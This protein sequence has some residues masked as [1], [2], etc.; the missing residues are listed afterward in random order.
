MKYYFL[1]SYLPE[2][3]REDKKIKIRFGDLL[4]EKN[5]IAEEDWLEVEHIL[6]ARDIFLLERLR[7]GREVEVEY[8]LDDP[9]LLKELVEYSQVGVMERW[10][11]R[12][13]NLLWE[14]YYD[15]VIEAT[16]SDFLRGYFQFE[17]DLRNIVAAVRARKRGLTVS[18]H[19]VGESD[20]VDLLQRAGG[21]DFGLGRE[22]PWIDRLLQAKDPIQFDEAVEE[23]LWEYIE[24]QTE[25]TDFEF[26]IVLAYLL[27]L[28][29]ME[30]R[31]SM[32]TEQGMEVVRQLE[33]L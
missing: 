17:K 7:S 13:I 22:Y 32:S 33:V 31:L 28:Q 26:D 12:E 23:A 19:M 2:L 15:H 30:R 9:R 6:L 14:M 29:L 24:E 16:K 25:Q 20:V 4:A 3:S 27:K 5:Q 1:V 11:P 8:T 18:D 21:E 10:G